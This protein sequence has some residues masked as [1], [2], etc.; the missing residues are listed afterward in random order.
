MH[1][2]KLPIS[3]KVIK[4]GAKVTKHAVLLS[5]WKKQVS[6]ALVYMHDISKPEDATA[7][8]EDF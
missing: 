4:Y 2:I 7:S 6:L 8:C 5:K 3:A 1:Q